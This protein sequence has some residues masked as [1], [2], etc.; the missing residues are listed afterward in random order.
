[1]RRPLFFGLLLLAGAARAD[2][3]YIADSGGSGNADK[4]FSF[5][6]T[7]GS[8]VS[9]NV[10]TDAT[11][12]TPLQAIPLANGNFL[13]LDQGAGSTGAGIYEYSAAGVRVNTLLVGGAGLNNF[14]PGAIVGSD[15]V[16]G[17]AGGTAAGTL[18]RIPLAGGAPSLF[19][20]VPSG[21]TQTSGPFGVTV[22]PDGTLLVSNS[23]STSGSSPNARVQR[24]SAAGAFLGDVVVSNTT[25]GLLFP[26]QIA[27]RPDGSFLVAGF[28]G[29]SGLYDYSATGAAQGFVSTGGGNRGVAFLDDGGVLT[30][31][32]TRVLK[33]A[34]DGT[35]TA[36]YTGTSA[37]SFRF[38][39]RA[40]PVPEPAS[41][42]ALGLGAL[43]L[44]RRRVHPRR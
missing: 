40:T 33:I 4:V 27:V 13:V 26:Q 15:F 11:L 14:R 17:V 36:V 10:F 24:F 39:S 29:T 25:T 6:S 42:A 35:Q 44:L 28:S 32:G 3:L 16:F 34:A 7:D 22:A 2:L 9:A 37:N 43:A 21:T 41:L 8:L 1:M 23:V 12:T 19:A 30:T 31:Q 18:Q 5:D 20:T 38:I